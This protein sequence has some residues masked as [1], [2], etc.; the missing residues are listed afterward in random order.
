MA[1]AH[2]AG[3]V[4]P[5]AGVTTWTWLGPV[6]IGIAS[7][8]VLYINSRR[9]AKSSDQGG[10][11]DRLL[12]RVDQYDAK[13]KE[14]DAKIAKQDERINFLAGEIRTRDDR[15]DVLED[16]NRGLKAELATLQTRLRALEGG[17]V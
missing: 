4:E 9:Q 1:V 3:E 7:S 10:F 14:L 17:A 6:L 5:V 15:I 12:K 13:E 11:Q 16:E 2:V 8:A